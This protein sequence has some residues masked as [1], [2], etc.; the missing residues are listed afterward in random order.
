MQQYSIEMTEFPKKNC[1][2]D[3]S[4][5]AELGVRMIY[6]RK[7]KIYYVV[8]DK[9]HEIVIVRILHMRENSRN[10][11]YRAFGLKVKSSYKVQ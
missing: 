8:N 6:Y 9:K 3:D 10:L 7:Y 4:Q 2:S 5:L 1:L 11:L